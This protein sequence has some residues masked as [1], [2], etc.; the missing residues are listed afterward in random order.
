MFSYRNIIL[1][2]LLVSV[3]GAVA[4]EDGLRRDLESSPQIS[5]DFEDFSPGDVVSDLGYGISVS[6][7]KLSRGKQM[8][9]NGKAM[10]F[11][12]SAPTGGDFDLGTP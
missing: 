6:A 1:S 2:L 3:S 5:I 7:R 4:K 10:I 8:L 11:D 12:S 9:R